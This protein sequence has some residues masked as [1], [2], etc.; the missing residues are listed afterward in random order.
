MKHQMKPI[1]ACAL[2]ALSFLAACSKKEPDAVSAA[3]ASDNSRAPGPTDWNPAAGKAALAADSGSKQT[4]VCVFIYPDAL[5]RGTNVRASDQPDLGMKKVSMNEESVEASSADKAHSIM[6]EATNHSLQ[7]GPCT[8]SLANAAVDQSIPLSSYAVMQS[9]LQIGLLYYGFQKATLPV[10]DLAQSFDAD[11]QS[12]SDSFKKQD[13]AKSIQA[14][15]EAQQRQELAS[16]YFVIKAGASLGHYDAQSK[17]FPILNLGVDGNSRL[18]MNDSP[19][20]GV[21]PRGDRRFEIV[22]P[23]SETEARALEAKVAATGTNA[24]PIN[25]DI[26][27]RA[28]DTVSYAARKDI[29]AKVVAVHVADQNDSSIA[30]IH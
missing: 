27:V 18:T 6:L 24:L 28:A 13:L 10:D 2:V 7:I 30:D 4:Y 22:V 8:A 9:G 15:Y 14:K 23:A 17:T 21:V 25:V 29:V 26:Y 5:Q 16:P 12:T 11:Y 1:A 19:T 3:P 20:Y